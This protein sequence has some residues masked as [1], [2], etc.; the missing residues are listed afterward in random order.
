MAAE[1]Q[2]VCH[3]WEPEYHAPIFWFLPADRGEDWDVPGGF[4]QDRLWVA[5]E[6]EEFGWSGAVD[7]V[8]SGARET[9]PQPLDGRS[10][11]ILWMVEDRI[12]DEARDRLRLIVE[13][14]TIE[15]CNTRREELAAW[16]RRRGQDR[17]AESLSAPATYRRPDSG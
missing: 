1:L 9:L 2:A 7:N 4:I 5:R 16:L 13:A 3:G 14:S 12:T 17:A 11:Q 8:I 6:V 15:E 10:I